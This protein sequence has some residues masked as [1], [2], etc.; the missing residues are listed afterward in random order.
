MPLDEFTEKEKTILQGIKERGE[1][2]CLQTGLVSTIPESGQAGY[3]VFLRYSEHVRRKIGEFS[4]QVSNSLSGRTLTYGIENSHQTIADC[5][6]CTLEG[7][8]FVPDEAVLEKLVI[9]AEKFMP[10]LRASRQHQDVDALWTIF[11]NYI[12]SP[13]SVILKPLQ[14]QG[15][16]F[17]IESFYN[18][19][20]SKGIEV[21][22]AWGR[23]ITVNRFTENIPINELGDFNNLISSA[24][25]PNESFDGD[26][27]Y[28]ETLGVGYFI[29]NKREFALKTFKCFEL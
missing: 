26:I 19:A 24:A 1:K 12:N 27:F 9:S 13:D 10:F 16:P 15:N 25:F 23:H 20:K 21:R 2:A 14:N 8:S 11:G 4:E 7:N 3:L 28:A 5:G 22:K 18:E 29:M 6:I 17:L